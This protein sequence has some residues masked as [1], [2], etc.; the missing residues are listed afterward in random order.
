MKPKSPIPFL[1][2]AVSVLAVLVLLGVL[3]AEAQIPR[4]QSIITTYDIRAWL[5]TGRFS[6]SVVVDR[7]GHGDFRTVAAAIAYV[8][9]KSP[10]E[11]HPWLVIV[12]GGN[13]EGDPP[14]SLP[15]WT[16][17]VF[18]GAVDDQG[19]SSAFTAVAPSNSNYSINARGG[20]AAALIALT[21]SANAW[22]AIADGGLTGTSGGGLFARG[23]GGF[24]IKA[25]AT[26]GFGLF[27]QTTSGSALF[28]SQTAASTSSL[29]YLQR[30]ATSGNVTASVLEIQ[31]I[32]TTSGTVTG[33][34]IH[35]TSSGGSLGAEA[36]RFAVAR[37]GSI[38]FA[39]GC[40]LV[41][42][43]GSPEG[44]VTAPVCSM[45]LRTDGANNTT[46]YVKTSGT[47]NTGWTAK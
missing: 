39:G 25:S 37:D 44:V 19:D 5:A 38:R 6:R 10:D 22:G 43:A 20:A 1:L 34:L 40:K 3:P 42:G 4:G 23:Y 2:S 18:Q 27:S 17:V 32:P 7:E 47:G 12:Y 35:A 24:G 8:T 14:W 41:A 30:R 36:E 21:R 16:S 15:S 13:H 28:A 31:D 29:A 9:S 26:T 45:Y 11:L 33:D 46:L